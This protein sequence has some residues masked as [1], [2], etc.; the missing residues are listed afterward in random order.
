M[1]PP[2]TG[3]LILR[4]GAY[5]RVR[6]DRE[7]ISAART[8]PV[9]EPCVTGLR[10]SPTRTAGGSTPPRSCGGS[11]VRLA[12]LREDVVLRA[13]VSP[14]EVFWRTTWTDRNL[15]SISQAGL[16]NNL[17]D[18]MAWG[19]F[20]LF[21]AAANLSLDRFGILATSRRHGASSSLRREPYRT[22]SGESG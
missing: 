12:T 18:G 21:F 15:S 19:L 16:V 22:A 10:T 8:A 14:R 13:D 1:L 17:N 20:P 11:A 7:P 5:L 3:D 9:D 4:Y 2:G 6:A